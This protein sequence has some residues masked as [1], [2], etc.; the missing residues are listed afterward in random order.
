MLERLNDNYSACAIA[1]AVLWNILSA[2]AIA[3]NFSANDQAFPQQTV[4]SADDAA[5]AAEAAKLAAEAAEKAA[6]AARAAA[7]AASATRKASYDASSPDVCLVHSEPP[8]ASSTLNVPEYQ[9]Y[10]SLV[11]A[12]YVVI[13]YNASQKGYPGQASDPNAGLMSWTD[14]T[15]SFDPK[16]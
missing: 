2:N 4:Q 8:S 14:Y 5:K 7:R 12:D 15:R 16:G 13:E 10:R 11:A 3:Q 6:D 9:S 1:V